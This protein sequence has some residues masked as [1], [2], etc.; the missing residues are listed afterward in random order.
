MVWTLQ[1]ANINRLECYEEAGQP[2]KSGAFSA[3]LGPLQAN[4]ALALWERVHPQ[5][6]CC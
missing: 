6:I 1:N 5:Y 4:G 3:A 2:W